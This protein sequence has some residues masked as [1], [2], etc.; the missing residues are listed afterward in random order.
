MSEKLWLSGE[1]VPSIFFWPMQSNRKIDHPYLKLQDYNI[2]NSINRK[3]IFAD[4]PFSDSWQINF[5]G[6]YPNKNWKN[7][8]ICPKC[9]S[10]ILKLSNLKLNQLRL[11]IL[12]VFWP[13]RETSRCTIC[14]EKHPQDHKPIQV[15]PN[16]GTQGSKANW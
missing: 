5:L 13:K 12:S 15:L 4:Q 7:I 11:C 3:R 9:H 8:F 16:L 2:S 10:T 6:C 1:T 14:R